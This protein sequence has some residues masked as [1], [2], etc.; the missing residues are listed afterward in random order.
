MQ[1]I[2]FLKDV[3]NLIADPRILITLAALFLFASLK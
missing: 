3:V 1:F 2:E